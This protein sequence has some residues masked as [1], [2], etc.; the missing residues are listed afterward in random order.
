LVSGFAF[1]GS[2]RAVVNL[3]GRRER[4]LLFLSWRSGERERDSRT[5][6]IES[7]VVALGSISG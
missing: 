2:M 6:F 3:C 4:R 7:L 1:D 5:G